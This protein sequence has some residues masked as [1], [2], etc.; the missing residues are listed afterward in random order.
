[1]ASVESSDGAMAPR[2]HDRFPLFDP[3][4]GLAAVAILLV[5]VAIFSGAA[6]GGSYGRF[7]IHLDIGVPFFFLLSGFLLYRPFVAA[8]ARD[9]RSRSLRTYASRRFLRIAPAYWAALTVTA[10]IPGMS[11]A[12][13]A[14]WWVY[15]GL[16]QNYPVYTAAGSCATDPYHCAIPPAWSLSI[17]V[18]FYAALPLFVLAA[19]WIARRSG[20]HWIRPE[21][22]FI[23]A[24]ALISIVI[25]SRVP[26]SDLGIWIFFSPLGRALWFGL[27]MGLASLSVHWSMA[28]NE[29]RVVDLV[30]R[31]PGPFLAAAAALYVLS[32]YVLDD[33]LVAFPVGD[34]TQYT[35]QYVVFGIIAA[36]ILLPA[37]FGH[38]DGGGV[39]R[40]LLRHPALT[41]LGL[42]SYGVFLWH[43]PVM[44]GL[45]DLGIIDFTS[46]PLISFVI[47]GATTLAVTAA[48]S[49][50]SYL[51]LERPLMRW[52]RRHEAR[53]DPAAPGRVSEAQP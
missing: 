25:Q 7:L 44:I 5:H 21:L 33:A 47:L 19:N 48:V 36:L 28:E 6:S 24:L 20:P 8:R 11:G 42:I 46:S 12:F 16:L 17:E 43:F 14:N 32:C 50:L 13:T 34:L 1:M 10:I 15:Y 39:W 3:L 22:G 29:P 38:D 30:R 52:G 45:L 53:E 9:R 41:W 49:T 40:A 31:R 51:Y 18:F 26:S 2:G 35:I 27:G 37:I 4:R 23:G